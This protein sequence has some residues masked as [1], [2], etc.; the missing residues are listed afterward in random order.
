ML[1]GRS[2]AFEEVEGCSRRRG[3]SCRPFPLALVFSSKPAWPLTEKTLDR[4]AS[5]GF[6]ILV[7]DRA[8]E[9]PWPR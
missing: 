6:A 3:Y 5:S 8:P 2:R 9:R 7:R 4:D 1:L